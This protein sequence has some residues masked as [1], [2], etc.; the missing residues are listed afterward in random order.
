MSGDMDTSLGNCT[1][2]CGMVWSFMRSL[3]VRKFEYMNDG[4]DGVLIV[5]KVASAAVLSAFET[6]FLQFGFTMK[7]EGV[8]EIME[9]VEF[10]Q[11]RPVY[12]GSVWRFV[13]NPFT[14]LAKDSLT[15][16]SAKTL[17]EQE[18]LSNSLGWCGSAL[19]GDL[20]LFCKFYP[21]F[22]RGEFVSLKGSLYGMEALSQ[23]MVPK[24]SEPTVEAR[25]SFARAF[26]ISP[27]K[28]LA[29]ESLFSETPFSLGAPSPTV[30]FTD[31]FGFDF[32]DIRDSN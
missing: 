10:C 4:D 9:E 8:A 14:C 19:A 12:D 21:R 20:P 25:V 1:T 27:E 18:E 17:S 23:R 22:I 11:C 31:L 28:Q 32:N 26:H 3:G 7:L 29:L 30:Y 24:F 2:M 6:Y 15:L 13:R 5:E 16:K